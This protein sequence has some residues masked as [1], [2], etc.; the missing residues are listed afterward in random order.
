MLVDKVI[1]RD[2]ELRMMWTDDAGQG[3]ALTDE[4][5]ALRLALG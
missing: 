3:T 5:A 2:A 4:I 1:T